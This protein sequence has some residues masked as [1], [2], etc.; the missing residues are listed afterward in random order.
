MRFST[1]HLIDFQVF[2]LRSS[3]FGLRSSVFGHAPEHWRI[4]LKLDLL[5]TSY[6]VVKHY[7]VYA[8]D[9]VAGYLV[10]FEFV[11]RAFDLFFE[12]SGRFSVNLLKTV[13]LAEDKYFT[14][15]NCRRGMLWIS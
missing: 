5:G 13:S 12:I 2:G 3:V 1:F 9:V 4:L 6:A 10:C 11:F 8:L 7:Y 14:P 15:L